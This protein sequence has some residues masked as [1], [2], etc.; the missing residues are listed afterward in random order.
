MTVWVVV[1]SATFVLATI[2]LFVTGLVVPAPTVTRL[3][4]AHDREVARITRDRD[5]EVA[6]LRDDA[7]YYRDAAQSCSMAVAHRE[8]QV[9]VLRAMLQQYQKGS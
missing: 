7:S 6:I 1:V 3:Q 8:A 5:A 9:A 4:G 2:L